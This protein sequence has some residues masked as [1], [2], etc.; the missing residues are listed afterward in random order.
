MEQ[1]FYHMMSPHHRV[2][3]TPES[4]LTIHSSQMWCHYKMIAIMVVV[5]CLDKIKVLKLENRYLRRDLF[6]LKYRELHIKTQIYLDIKMSA[7]LQHSK[8][9]WE[10]MLVQRLDIMPHS[11]RECFH[12]QAAQMTQRDHHQGQ[13]KKRNGW[14][15]YS[16]DPFKNSARERSWDK[17]IQE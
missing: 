12:K 3:S 8:L 16:R 2:V 9:H 10:K 1:I 13:D 7:V 4:D 17:L 15:Q 14:A 6:I 5:V 11:I